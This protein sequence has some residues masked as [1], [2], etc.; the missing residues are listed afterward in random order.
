MNVKSYAKVGAAVGAAVL[1][2][3][4]LTT[5]ASA[6][7]SSLT[8]Y[9]TLAAVGSD[10][11][12][13]V[14]NGL[15]NGGAVV[16]AGNNNVI[17]SWN[18]VD[19]LG[20]PYK[21]KPTPASSTECQYN[22]AD[23]NGSSNG[24]GR[25][26]E[27]IANGGTTCIDIVRSSR[28]PKTSGTDLTYVPFARDAVTYATDLGS[29]VPTSLSKDQLRQIYTDCTYTDDT[30][31]H[32]VA[33]LLPQAGSGTRQYWLDSIGVPTPGACVT[34]GIQEHDGTAI[35]A[36]NQLMPYS[37][38]QWIAQ[39]KGIAEVPNRRGESRLRS[40]TGGA[41]GSENPTTGSGTALALNPNFVFSR[42]V[43]NVVQTSRLN[44]DATISKAL[45]DICAAGTTIQNY[46]FGVI[47]NCN[48]RT[49]TGGLNGNN[50]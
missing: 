12:Q 22:R 41:A 45:S 4:I 24:L 20:D 48:D 34:Q 30:G 29:T 39:G 43:Y 2:L 17:A 37:V 40:I 36:A 18:A 27:D 9:R 28:G 32:T 11:T 42:D 50:S 44:S 21:T 13:Y 7:P 19:G 5:P 31:T 8:D 26:A 35:T 33:P 3:G 16:D 38:A 23:T 15:A 14:M 10:T 49:L 47:S 6:D 1:G 25:L 46:G